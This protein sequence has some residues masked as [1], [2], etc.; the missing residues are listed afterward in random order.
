MAEPTQG[1]GLFDIEDEV[2]KER[3]VAA[4]RAELAAGQGVPWA[5]V[6]RRLR[7]WGKA[8]ELSPPSWK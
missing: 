6:K 3:A 2:A 5:E 8:D 1:C 7:S 4:A